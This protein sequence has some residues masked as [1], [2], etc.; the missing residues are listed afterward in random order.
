MVYKHLL[1]LIAAAA[2]ALPGAAQMQKGE[3]SLGP[4]VGYI[5]HNNSAVAGL[6]FQYALSSRVRLAPE[7]ACAFRHHHEDALIVDLNVHVP[8]ELGTEKVSLYP[9][10]GLSFNSWSTHGVT[11]NDEVDVTTHTNRFGLNA[12]AGFD[13]RCSPTLKLG[14][15]AKYNLVKSY[16]SAIITASISYIF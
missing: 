11:R 5:S 3:K 15:E 16:S 13:L 6:A 12:G 2:V 9:L 8:F 7:I 10:A 4:K 14:L 1:T